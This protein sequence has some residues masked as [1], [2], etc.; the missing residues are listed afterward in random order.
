[1]NKGQQALKPNRRRMHLLPKRKPG[2]VVNRNP[3]ARKV[4]LSVLPWFPSFYFR[5]PLVKAAESA[6]RITV[7]MAQPGK[8]FGSRPGKG[9]P[10]SP[11]PGSPP[12]PKSKPNKN[13]CCPQG[14]FEFRKHFAGP[15]SPPQKTNPTL[16]FSACKTVC[17]SPPPPFP[18]HYPPTPSP[19]LQPPNPSFFL[20]FLCSLSP[21]LMSTFDQYRPFERPRCFN[22]SDR[23]SP[24]LARV[25]FFPQ[26]CFFCTLTRTVELLLFSLF[27]SVPPWTSLSFFYHLSPV[28]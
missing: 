12:W 23:V 22:A 18:P 11:K 14:V 5:D 7:P 17:S 20:V 24:P 13:T 3:G 26:L 8:G 27:V 6:A 2:A 16:S 25:H 9:F 28:V 4:I 1:V 21:T 10:R 19:I 15:R